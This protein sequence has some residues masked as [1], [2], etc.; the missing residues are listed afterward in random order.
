MDKKPEFLQQ[1]RVTR[2]RKSERVYNEKRMG[3]E[4][5]IKAY[6]NERPG[7]VYTVIGQTSLKTGVT[8]LEHD[9]EYGEYAYYAWQQTGS[10]V[11]YI[12][13]DRL[14]RRYLA[15]VEDMTPVREVA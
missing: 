1:V 4:R 2:F 12:V 8:S 3:S 10:M 11:V 15:A 6:D 13:A 9:G 14:S 7:T 5:V